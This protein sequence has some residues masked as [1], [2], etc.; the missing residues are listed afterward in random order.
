MYIIEDAGRES[1]NGYTGTLFSTQSFHKFKTT[2]K[3]WNL[4]IYLKDWIFCEW[5]GETF[6]ARKQ[7]DNGLCSNRILWRILLCREYT[8]GAKTEAGRRG[9]A[10]E[11]VQARDKGV[12]DH[13]GDC[14]RVRNGMDRANRI[15]WWTGG[16][17]VRV[18]ASIPSDLWLTRRKMSTYLWCPDKVE[19][20][21]NKFIS[22]CTLKRAI[23][24][25]F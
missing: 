19:N 5:D 2:L 8:E 13:G 21:L 23:K 1:G 6:E 10:V 3:P 4:L 11:I 9:G 20:S 16:S 24:K 14:H 7:T 18:E 12:L 25:L 17:E 15:F 22:N